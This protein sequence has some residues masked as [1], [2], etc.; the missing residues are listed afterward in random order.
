MRVYHFIDSQ[1]AEFDVATLCRVC[2]VSRSTYYDWRTA[3]AAG[4]GDARGRRRRG[5]HL[6]QQRVRMQVV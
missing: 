1:K 2:G 6:P 5:A 4:P 3:Q